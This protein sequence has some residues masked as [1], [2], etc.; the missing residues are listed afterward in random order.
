MEFEKSINQDV[1]W[2]QRFW[3]SAKTSGRVKQRYKDSSKENKVIKEERGWDREATNYGLQEGTVA[4]EST[5]L[6]A[7]PLLRLTGPSWQ[8][9]P[10]QKDHLL[11][12]ERGGGQMGG[13]KEGRHCTEAFQSCVSETLAPSQHSQPMCN[14]LPPLLPCWHTQQPQPIWFHSGSLL[15]FIFKVQATTPPPAHQFGLRFFQ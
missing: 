10:E 2:G 1:K 12:E 6:G 7:W 4:G 8:K 11:E 13:W 3:I 9:T 14:I 5:S 15:A